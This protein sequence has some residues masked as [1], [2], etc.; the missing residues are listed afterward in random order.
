MLEGHGEEDSP[1]VQGHQ[2]PEAQRPF[3]VRARFAE[4]LHRTPTTSGV[5]PSAPI[6]AM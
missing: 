2:D 1:L 3:L 5:R 6:V 4:G